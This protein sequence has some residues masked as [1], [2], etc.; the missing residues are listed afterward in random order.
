[1]HFNHV[2]EEDDACELEE[3]HHKD[4]RLPDAP[5]LAGFAPPLSLRGR[6]P[7]LAQGLEAEEE[8]DHN[9]VGQGGTLQ[10]YRGLLA[11]VYSHA[12][13]MYVEL[14]IVVVVVKLRMMLDQVVSVAN[15]GHGK[16][17]H[18]LRRVEHRP[19]T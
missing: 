14:P 7:P 2:E 3:E 16:L 13:D 19:D 8:C 1:M 9:G 12:E 4:E 6:D 10:G 17:G 15:V 11:L 18:L 5:E